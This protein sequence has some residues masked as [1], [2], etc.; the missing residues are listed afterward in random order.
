[1]SNINKNSPIENLSAKTKTMGSYGK[2]VKNLKR[3]RSL[4]GNCQNV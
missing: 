4:Q 1:M 2:S 3:K